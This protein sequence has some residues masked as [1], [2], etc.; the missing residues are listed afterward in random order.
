MK[1]VPLA[2][3]SETN[4]Q[5]VWKTNALVLDTVQSLWYNRG[6]PLDAYRAWV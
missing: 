1:F 3:K 5:H 6:G 4:S 2:G